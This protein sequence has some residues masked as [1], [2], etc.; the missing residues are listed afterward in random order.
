VDELDWKAFAALDTVL[1][2]AGAAA[3]GG[4]AP[5]AKPDGKLARAL[6]ARVSLLCSS[7]PHAT[8]TVSL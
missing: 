3:R 8:V 7:R 5:G 4:G 2:A 1:H 6:V